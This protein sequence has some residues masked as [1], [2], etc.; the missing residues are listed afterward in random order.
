MQYT[1]GRIKGKKNLKRDENNN[2]INQYNVKFSEEEKRQ[3]ESLVNSA[4]RKRKR[5]ETEFD[6]L[7]VFTG[8]HKTGFT[9]GELPGFMGKENDF[10]LTKK[11]KSL[12]RFRNKTDYRHYIKSLKK[13]VDKNYIHKRAELYRKN[14]I[15]ALR[16]VFGRDA[17]GIIKKIKSIGPDEY[18]KMVA[19]DESLQIKYIGS[20]YDDSEYAQIFGL[21]RKEQL[22]IIENAINAISKK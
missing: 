19:S 20:D 3:L 11:T 22:T 5:M 12:N 14:D 21:Q 18:M 17:K 2:Y 4:N 7:P 15:K 10:V 8:G 9:I 1:G 6:N 16:K 13:V